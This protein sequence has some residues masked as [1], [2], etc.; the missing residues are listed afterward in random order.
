MG[1]QYAQRRVGVNS[2]GDE[3]VE[4]KTG[5]H[6]YSHARALAERV[7]AHQGCADRPLA[8]SQ[9]HAGAGIQDTPGAAVGV[10]YP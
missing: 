1:G 4:G 5:P 8:P 2:A 7:G 10:T 6:R 3:G 9:R